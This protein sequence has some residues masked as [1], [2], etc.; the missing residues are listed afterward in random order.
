MKPICVA[1]S[2]DFLKPDGSPAYPGF[3]F[4][5]LARDPS[6]EFHFLDTCAQIERA[7]IADVDVL[8]LS[9]ARVTAGSFHPDRRLGLI[10]QFGAGFD[11]IDL[12]AATANA[13]AVTNTPAGVRRPMAVAIMT[14]I[15]ALVT[16]LPA[17]SDLAREGHAGWARAAGLTGAGLTG[18]TLS[19]IG[20]GNIASDLFH[21]MRPL[22]MRFIAHDPY[23]DA[24][25]AEALG[26]ELVSC[27]D[28][29]ALAD[30]LTVNCPLTADT[31]HIADARH[32]AL[33]KPSAYFVNTSRGGTVDQI[34]LIEALKNRRVAGAAL[35]VFEEEPLPQ[36]SPLIGLDNV[37]L[38]PHSLCWSNELY[39][40][41]GKDAIGATLDFIAG[42]AP[43]SIVNRD[44]ATKPEWLA[45]LAVNRD[46][47][48]TTGRSER[49]LASN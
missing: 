2:G 18:M 12:D 38:T 44:V 41:C 48:G 6:I 43:G 19:S 31:H 30:I 45:R 26:V 35:D 25:R 10:A 8:I 42:R 28:A 29:F 39:S 7:Q 27:E 40:G 46:S 17:K 5:P 4:A 20:L 22:D 37:I 33:M 1:A 32:I 24:G 15:L 14:L 23:A 34:A 9:G 36:T 16:R 3:D 49:M 11:H 47:F 21:V 13:V